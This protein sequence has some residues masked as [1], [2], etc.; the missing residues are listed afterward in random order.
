MLGKG[1]RCG[2]AAGVAGATLSLAIPSMAQVQALEARRPGASDIVV[3]AQRRE[4]SIQD[5][6][7]AVSAFDEERLDDMQIGAAADL[8]LFVP[9]FSYTPTNY[10]GANFTIRGVGASVLGD[11]ADTGVALHYNGVFLQGGGNSNLYYDVE[12]VEVLRGPQGTL[13]GRNATGGAVNLRTKKPTDRL[14]GEIWASVGTAGSYSAEAVLNLPVSDQLAFRFAGLRAH[15]DGDTHNFTTGNRINGA[16]TLSAR[17]TMR[18]H[19]G[20]STIIDASATFLSEK[21]DSMQAHKRLCARDVQ[22]VLGCSPDRLGFE[23]PDY[24]ATLTGLLADE[25]GI[26]P[27]ED[28][29][30]GSRN[31]TNMR[32]VAIDFDPRVRNRSWISSL[33]I[34]HGF[35]PLT[36]TSLS[37]F[38]TDRGSYEI[39]P[40]FAVASGAFAPSPFF[41]D[42]LFPASIADP[43]NLGSLADRVSG[44]FGGPWSLERGDNRGRQWVSE[45]RLASAYQSRFDFLVGAFFIDSRKQENLYN[46]ATEIDAFGLLQDVA[47]PFS[48]L[49][50]PRNDL[51]SFALFGET[52]WQLSDDWRLTVG[53]RW[54]RD[55]KVQKNRNLLLDLPKDF[56]TRRLT[57]SAVTGRAVI[58]WTPDLSFARDTLIYASLARGYKGGGFNPQG[59]IFVPPRFDPEYVNAIELGSKHDL[60]GEASVNSAIFFYDYDGL[61]V[62]KTVNRTSI[63]ENIDAR[64]WGAEV[65]AGFAVADG[66]SLDLAL[67]Y[68][69][70]RIG[71]AESI[72]P[73]DPVGGVSGHVAIKD[74]VTGGHCVATTL[75]LADLLQDI[76]FGDCEELGLSSG[77][78]V[79]L[80]GNRLPNAP[81]W[82][83]RIGGEWR[84]AVGDK[85]HLHVRADY[86]IRSDFWGRIFNRDPVDRIQGWGVL[87]AM[88]EL[89]PIEGRWYVR[90]VASNLLNSD[91]VT[92][93]F[94]TDATAGLATNLFMLPARRVSLVLGARF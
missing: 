40:D 37:S 25:I 45:L 92:G 21:G 16:N 24:P 72:D 61:Q 83:V 64:I 10:G 70:T 14:E 90:G 20:T 18:L 26:A 66:L 38:A 57:D 73:R 71:R 48:R 29:F 23:F 55:R 46:I 9:N 68:L 59:R 2:C 77:N 67:S 12:A 86:S 34:E 15:D 42:G 62:S 13:F 56:E 51:R 50:T 43:D 53:A 82:T 93:M 35:G 84:E 88:V 76:P 32:Q 81:A 60:G 36:L 91:A 31:P 63:N 28:P 58:E 30:L 22:G 11:G 7:I 85:F 33:N 65:E 8:Q 87:N 80:R 17:A 52:Y 75:Q 69:S 19:I 4:Q 49:E 3:T 94:V 54:T 5:V 41:P 1:W 79:A 78:P 47:P 74:V 39:D 6:P 27:V 44:L 89:A